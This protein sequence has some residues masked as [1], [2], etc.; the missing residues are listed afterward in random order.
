M[1]DVRGY[2]NGTFCW[3]DL[4]TPDVDAARAFYRGLFGWE[5]EEVPVPGSSPY[6]LCRVEGKDVAGIHVHREEEAAVWASSISVH[7]VEATTSRARDLGATVLREPFDVMATGREA[8][9]RDPVGAMVS[10]WQPG[11]HIG[12]GLVNEI[13]TWGWNELSTSDF[14]GAWA[15]YTGLFGWSTEE[16]PGPMRRAGFAMGHLLIAG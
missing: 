16:A 8:V 6:V 11:S 1:G 5:T 12:A 7:D 14:A 9:L 3:V 2:P 10:L 13:H 15:F 4:A